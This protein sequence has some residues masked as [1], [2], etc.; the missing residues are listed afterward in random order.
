MSW[1]PLRTTLANKPLI[2]AGP[3]LCK[4]TDSS[5]TVRLAPFPTANSRIDRRSQLP[6]VDSR[7]SF[8]LYARA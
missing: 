6:P 4:V 5:V 8:A 3:M 1:R 7:E 2:F